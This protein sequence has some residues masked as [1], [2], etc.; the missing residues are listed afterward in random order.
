MLLVSVSH[1]AVHDNTSGHLQLAILRTHQLGMMSVLVITSISITIPP[2]VGGDYFC[3][4]GVNSGS[5]TGGFHPDNPLWDGEGCSSSSSCCSLNNP[6]YFTRQLPSPTSDPIEARL[7]RWE[8]DQDDS[9][10]EFM[11]LYVK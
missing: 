5:S 4:S 11:E 6:L 1:M 9:P 10:V 8:G 2:F 7:W 3:E